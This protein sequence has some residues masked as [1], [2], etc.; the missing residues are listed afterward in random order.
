M[1]PACLGAV[2]TGAEVLDPELSAGKRVHDRDVGAAVV[3][4]QLLD[5]DPVAAVEADGAAEEAGRSRRF[6]IRQHLGVGEAAVVVDGDVHVLPAE[7][8][9]HLASLVGDG[10]GVVLQVRDVTR[11]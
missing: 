10:R 2:G 9:P 3:G 7:R 1:S 5:L 11:C 8:A 6:L 4:E